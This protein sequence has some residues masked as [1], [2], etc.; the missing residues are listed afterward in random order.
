MATYRSS[1]WAYARFGQ[2]QLDLRSKQLLRS[3]NRIPIQ[4][5]PLQVLRL[6]LDADGGVV[7]RE[8]VR[9]ALWPEDTFVD[10]EH[11]VNTAVKKLRQALDDSADR[12]AYIETLPR[13][14]YRFLVRVEW[15]H[16]GDG[17]EIHS[18]VV[19]LP[20]PEVVHA[21]HLD[22]VPSSKTWRLRLMLGTALCGGLVTLFGG[23]AL[24]RLRI[25]P[26]QTR[27]GA[28]LHLMGLLGSEPSSNQR[29]RRLTANPDE[30][31]LT[32]SAISPDGK[33]LAFT[34][35]TGFYLRLVDSGETH[36]VALPKDFDPS[37]EGWFPDS[38][39][40][41]VSWIPDANKPPS[42][43]IISALGGAPRRLT[44]VGSGARVSPD[45][46]QVAFMKGAWDDSE[47]WLVDTNG[48]DA[49]K[50]FDDRVDYFGPAAWA[51][52]G[53]RLAFVRGSRERSV[54]EIV[55]FELRDGH[56]E[57]VLSAS[58]LGQG[59]V[60]APTG[61][62]IYSR[63]EAHPNQGDSN[64]WQL[65]LNARTGRSS[66][67]PVRLTNDHDTISAISLTS[68][69]RRLAMIRATGQADVYLADIEEQGKKLSAPRRFTLDQ[70]QDFPSSWT[71]D[72]NE[73]LVVSDRDGPNHIFRQRVD[74]AQAELLVG[75]DEDVWLPHMTP[76]GSSVLYLASPQR[77]GSAD[78]VRLMRIALDGGP[79][80][81]VLEEP[82]IVNYQCARLPSQVCVYGRIDPEYYRFF[83]FDPRDGTR[84][85]LPALRVSKEIGYN[86]WNLSPDGRYLAA[87]R[88]QDPYQEPAL[89]VL[90]I[91]DGTER[92]LP[93]TGLKLIVGIDWAADSMSLWVGGYMGR[94]SWGARAGLIN[95]DLRGHARTLIDG[96][97][98]LVMGATP[99]PDG[100][101]LA[102]GAST[103]SANVWLLE[104]F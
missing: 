48:N 60:W 8:E 90:S 59:L 10:F 50:I 26:G 46:K 102:L 82:G 94:G 93:V 14:G 56:T 79:S 72:S 12:P 71:A 100:R 23:I 5:K 42:L 95:V 63:A 104:N 11:G 47:I 65:N 92:L 15:I 22:P 74:Q 9:A 73:V 85:E 30:T 29:S 66:G 33:Y 57:T 37:V 77:V 19:S 34:D 51:P 99:S 53:K 36:S 39:H 41:V 54:G 62:I 61:H 43:W 21:A 3:G 16:S 70:R 89:R 35:S 87:S 88:S 17:A 80:H 69:G 25:E 83:L 103:T 58:G 55:T 44:E 1:P 45:G 38:A 76:D 49:R 13:V 6:L 31:P 40:L 18:N 97:H 64:L 96:Y 68:D 91:A 32:S 4:D 24:S 101:R 52:D 67:S 28:V 20:V 7:T 78:K 86:S 27:V 75:G 98:P 81:L 84:S 2:F